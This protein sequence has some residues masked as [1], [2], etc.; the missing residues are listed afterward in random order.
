MS[1]EVWTYSEPGIVVLDGD[2]V[3]N[4]PA[5]L[6]NDKV[7]PLIQTDEGGSV[8]KYFIITKVELVEGKT[9][10]TLDG[11][12]KYTLT[13]GVITFHRV[14]SWT[15][16]TA[17]FPLTDPAY[18][19]SD[20]THEGGGG[21]VTGPASA[22]ADNLVAFDGTD[23]KAIKDSGYPST[24]LADGWVPAG[25]T[26]TYVSANTFKISG[27][28]TSKYSAGMKVKL[29]QSSTVKHFF[30]TK[31]EYSSPD[32]TVTVFGGTDYT[33][34]DATIS[35]PG[36]SLVKSPFGFPL[37]PAKWTVETTSTSDSSQ[38]NPA[39]GAWYNKGGSLAI[40]IGAWK[41][42]YSALLAATE[43]TDYYVAPV[44]ATLSTAN[45]T[46]SEKKYT[47][48]G[49][50]FW[51]AAGSGAL[52]F[53]VDLPAAYLNLAAA[54][55]YYLNIAVKIAGVDSIAVKGATQTTVI[56]A[57]CAYL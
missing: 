17:G 34:A 29:T 24:L 3:N 19:A 53:S 38:S 43:N 52:Y 18:S 41:V 9:Y 45:N 23:G 14:S 32:T 51:V 6:V 55:T 13:E 33:L 37:D 10:L 56:R 16:P 2:F 44:F 47:R 31:V 25:E 11:K 39:N 40:P 8:E 21:D 28:K 48:G 57:V 46:E 4:P 15:T 30:V 20:H 5:Y 7:T 1:E 54:A 26:W 42:S 35:S 27:D 36:Y 22:V 50:L 12:G 49:N